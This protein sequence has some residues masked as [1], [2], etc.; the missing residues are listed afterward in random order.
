LSLDAPVDV[1]VVIEDEKDVEAN[2]EDVAVYCDMSCV[3]YGYRVD[4]E[5]VANESGVSLKE[6]L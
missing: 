6:T 3:I 1:A 5:I 2:V 4:K